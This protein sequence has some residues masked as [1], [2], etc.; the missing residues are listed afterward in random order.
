MNFVMPLTAFTLYV[1]KVSHL[2]I[3]IAPKIAE[4]IV[5]TAGATDKFRMAMLSHPEVLLSV[6]EYVPAGH[7]F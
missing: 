3:L 2:L 4:G 5:V 1:C 6:V 7:K